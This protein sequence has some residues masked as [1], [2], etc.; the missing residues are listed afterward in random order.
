MNEFRGMLRIRHFLFVTFFI[1]SFFIKIKSDHFYFLFLGLILFL[2]YKYLWNNY[3][4]NKKVKKNE[5]QIAIYLRN[6]WIIQQE[7]CRELFPLQFRKAIRKFLNIAAAAI[8]PKAVKQA[9]VKN[10]RIY[11]FGEWSFGVVE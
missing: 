2:R 11:K 6:K 4:Y 9:P 8:M 10:S 7:K 5:K 1:N 3:W